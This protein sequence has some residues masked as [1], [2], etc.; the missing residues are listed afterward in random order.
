MMM[1][2]DE[3]KAARA[4][5]GL[6]AAA[7]AAALGV[8]DARGVRRYEAADTDIPG[9]LT[10]AVRYVLK[11]GLDKVAVKA[12]MAAA[13]HDGARRRGRRGGLQGGRGPTPSAE[14]SPPA[15]DD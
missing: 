11:H 14:G 10:V 1:T 12:I 15:S 3:L 2:P 9:P 8:S 13:E 4:K 6:S 5:L 7:F